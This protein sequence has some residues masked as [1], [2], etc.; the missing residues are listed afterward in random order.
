MCARVCVFSPVLK[1]E[2]QKVVQYRKTS[3]RKTAA[4]HPKFSKDLKVELHQQA[5]LL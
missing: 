5:K 1:N 2:L 4:Q 3:K